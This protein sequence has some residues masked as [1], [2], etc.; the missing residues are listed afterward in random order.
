FHYPEEGALLL[1]ILIQFNCQHYQGVRSSP[2][3]GCSSSSQ[4]KELRGSNITSHLS[5][6][7]VE[8]RKLRKKFHRINHVNESMIHRLGL[9]KELEGHRGCV[10]CLEWNHDGS[11]LAS[12]SDDLHAIIWDPQ[13]QKP[14]CTLR[15]GHHG[16]IF[17]LKF[18][19]NANDTSIVTAAGDCKVHV[20]NIPKLETSEVYSCHVGR[21]KRLATAP[22]VPYMFWSAGEDGTVRPS[23]SYRNESK[24]L[25][26]VGYYLSYLWPKGDELLVNIGGEQVYLFDVNKARRPKLYTLGDYALQPGT[27]GVHKKDVSEQ[28][29][30][31]LSSNGTTNGVSH[32]ISLTQTGSIKCLPATCP[33]HLYRSTHQAEFLK[34]EANKFYCDRKDFTAAIRLYNQAISISPQSAVLYGNRAAAYMKRRWDGDLYASI[35]D[36]HSALQLDPAHRKAHFRLA[37]GLLELAWINEAKVCLNHFKEKFPEYSEYRECR[38]L[39]G[40]IRRAVFTMKESELSSEMEAERPSSSASSSS[41]SLG[42]SSPIRDIHLSEH[43][44]FFRTKAFDYQERFCGHCNTTTDIKEANFFGSDGQYIMAGSDDGSFFIWDRKT[45]NIIRVLRGD[46][47]IVNCLQ[48]HPTSCLLASSGI[49]PV[50]RLWSPRPEDG[51]MEER[52]IKEADSAATANQRRMKADPFEVMLLNMGL[53]TTAVPGET[54]DED[55]A[56]RSVQCHQS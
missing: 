23:T 13:R 49:D 52:C 25:Q 43:E 46:D 27:N 2:S 37:R 11:L 53:S 44:R 8:Y 34:L 6:R 55:G 3:R 51:S 17:S 48:P 41:P 7:S 30:G 24:R 50:V 33:P 35:R 47:S 26:N 42:C 22:N 31:V 18:L 4:P 5:L 14:K 39:D 29:A 56:E 10:N 15:T 9:E 54:S 28:V 19:P 20:H 38:M 36:C 45:T 12:G 40:D 16:N 32:S 1:S 21:V